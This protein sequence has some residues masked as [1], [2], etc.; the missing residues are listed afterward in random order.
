MSDVV[1]NSFYKIQIFCEPLSIS[2]SDGSF[3]RS[4]K[5]MQSY[6]LCQVGAEHLGVMDWLLQNLYY[7]SPSKMT[8]CIVEYK[9]SI[10][11]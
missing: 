5:V 10:V 2:D 4:R 6:H 1:V 9:S 8:L 3:R 7:S 11:R